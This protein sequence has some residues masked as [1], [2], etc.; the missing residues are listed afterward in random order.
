DGER[1]TFSVHAETVPGVPFRV[2][3][4]RAEADG[5]RTGAERG[6]VL[7]RERW[8]GEGVAGGE[9][10]HFDTVGGGRGAVLDGE[11]DGGVVRGGGLALVE[12][13]EAVEAAEGALQARHCALEGA[14]RAQAGAD[15]RLAA[16]Q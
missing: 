1:G 14:E 2:V 15:L 9:A 13:A 11:A 7:V 6:I 16:R 12:A 3:V 5:E 4:E 10:G 8:T